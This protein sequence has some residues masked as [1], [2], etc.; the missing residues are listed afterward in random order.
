MACF[1]QENERHSFEKCELVRILSTT[2]TRSNSEFAKLSFDGIFDPSTYIGNC[3]NSLW[4]EWCDNK[5]VDNDILRNTAQWDEWMVNYYNCCKQD[6]FNTMSEMFCLMQFHT[7]SMNGDYSW[8]FKRENLSII[9]NHNGLVT[10][11]LVNKL[12]YLLKKHNFGSLKLK[13]KV[14]VFLVFCF[15][16]FVFLFFIVFLV[17]FSF[18]F[19]LAFLRC[20]ALWVH[21]TLFFSLFLFFLGGG[22]Q[23]TNCIV[24][25]YYCI[26]FCFA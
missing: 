24:L 4:Q 20:F 7:Q 6:Y 9:Q 23:L 19:A 8:A 21:L 26:I 22:G 13:T 15:L 16:L 12:E 14:S 3:Y 2:I 25:L 11:K 17:Y 18:F 1:D 5:I 10:T